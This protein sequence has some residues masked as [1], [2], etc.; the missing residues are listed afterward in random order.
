MAVTTYTS[1]SNIRTHSVN[2]PFVT[3][4][5]VRFTHLN[6]VTYVDRLFHRH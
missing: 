3:A 1:Y 2:N 4:A 6:T 5:G